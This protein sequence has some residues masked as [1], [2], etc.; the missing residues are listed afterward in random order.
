[1]KKI[2]RKSFAGFKISSNF[3]LAF[4]KQRNKR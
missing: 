4:G 3:A 1:M 2:I